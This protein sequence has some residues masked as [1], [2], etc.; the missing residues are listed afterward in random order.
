LPIG[1]HESGDA[2]RRKQLK[3]EAVWCRDSNRLSRRSF[4]R[5]IFVHD[6]RQSPQARHLGTAGD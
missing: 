6:T 2:N 5:G 4:F 3:A 1:G